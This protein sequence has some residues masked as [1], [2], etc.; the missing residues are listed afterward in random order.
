MIQPHDSLASYMYN[1]PVFGWINLRYSED[2]T[3]ILTFGEPP[4]NKD[5]MWVC[6]N[7]SEHRVGCFWFL[8]MG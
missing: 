2:N 6:L 7:M 8:K 1:Y 3:W 4:Q 5:L